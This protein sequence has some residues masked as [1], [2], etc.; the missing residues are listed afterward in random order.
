MQIV[1][2]RNIVAFAS[3]HS[4]QLHTKHLYFNYIYGYP[5]YICTFYTDF[6]QY[7]M[8]YFIKILL[9]LNKL[10]PEEVKR[11]KHLFKGFEQY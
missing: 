6:I 2:V 11:D 9:T 7:I 5:V 8:S 3:L 4:V 1:R 10:I